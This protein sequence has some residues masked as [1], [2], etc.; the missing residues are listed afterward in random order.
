MG[1]GETYG[2]PGRQIIPPDPH[3]TGHSGDEK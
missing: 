1:A 2:S 3:T